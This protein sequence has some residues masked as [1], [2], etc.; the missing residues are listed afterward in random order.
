MNLPALLHVEH[1]AIA[2]EA[3]VAGPLVAG[4]HDEAAVLVELGGER[5][6]VLPER[7]GDLKIVALVA[8][9][10]QESL[11]AGE[12]EEIP[13]RVGADGLLGLPVEIA[14]VVKQRGVGDDA[15]RIRARE[16]SA[17]LVQ[18]VDRVVPRLLRAQAFDGAR[19][20]TRRQAHRLGQTIDVSTGAQRQ[21]L[22]AFV[23]WIAPPVLTLQAQPERLAGASQRRQHRLPHGRNIRD[24]G[25]LR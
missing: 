12:I 23:A 11:V 1:V 21:R 6:Q 20:V 16:Q 2:T 8:A 24:D 14:P 7:R 5:V 3:G 13:R 10:I 9:G 17:V 19:E 18:D 25:D 4:K 22:V 15:K